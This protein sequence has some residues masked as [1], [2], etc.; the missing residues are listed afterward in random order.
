MCL[1]QWFPHH[2]QSY[3]CFN[4]GQCAQ[5]LLFSVSGKTAYKCLFFLGKL[6]FYNRLN[7]FAPQ[8][9]GD[10]HRSLQLFLLDFMSFF[11]FM[12]LFIF[13]FYR[14]FSSIQASSVPNIC[15]SVLHTYFRL[16][17]NIRKIQDSKTNYTLFLESGACVH[18]HTH[19]HTHMR[20]CV[21]LTAASA[22]SSG[23]GC[24]LML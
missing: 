4:D 8:N 11:W 7:Y 19:T 23:S 16:K 21:A 14:L 12:L 20:A 5:L 2:C 18:A 3:W 13:H 24:M 17:V 6:I 22:H 10:I 1:Q 15:M 9:G